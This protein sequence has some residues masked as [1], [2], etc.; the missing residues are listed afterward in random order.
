MLKLI[1]QLHACAHLFA[2]FNLNDDHSSKDEE[3]PGACNAF[4][5]PAL[6]H[7]LVTGPYF[8]INHLSHSIRVFVMI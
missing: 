7:S 1:L 2:L 8:L 6:L 4:L 5:F 3:S